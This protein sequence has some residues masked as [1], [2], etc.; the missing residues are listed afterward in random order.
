MVARDT[1]SG[2]VALLTVLIVG[3]VAV[4]AALVL[5]ATSADS[6]RTA[7]IAQQSKQ[8]RSLAVACGEEG[9]QAIRENIY[10]TGTASL[11][12]GQGTCNYT[13]ASTAISTRTIT[14]VATVN[15]T[16]RKIQINVTIGTSNISIT[17]WQDVS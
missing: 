2:Y 7:L 5:V 16:S 8:A 12:L 10:Y 9:L 4:A 6:Q 14:V 1:Q 17:S 15:N 11:T 13:I 3:A